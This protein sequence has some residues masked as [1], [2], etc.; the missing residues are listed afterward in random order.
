MAP[1]YAKLATKT[2][3]NG[4]VHIIEARALAGDVRLANVRF[5]GAAPSERERLAAQRQL[6]RAI[7][8]DGYTLLGAGR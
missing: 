4:T 8:R 3:E 5:E 7:A 1:K 2:L 6:A